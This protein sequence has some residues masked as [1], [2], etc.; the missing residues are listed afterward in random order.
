LSAGGSAVLAG[1]I[2][3]AKTSLKKSAASAAT[4]GEILLG[5]GASYNVGDHLSCD[6]L[7]FGFEND[8]TF[9]G[10]WHR[11]PPWLLGKQFRGLRLRTH[12]SKFFYYK[13]YLNRCQKLAGI[14]NFWYNMFRLRITD[15][16]LL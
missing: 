4:I 14:G 12:T 11:V 7:S 2:V 3:G 8:F 6:W 1:Y 5:V 15:F 9:F 16:W 13:L 10:T